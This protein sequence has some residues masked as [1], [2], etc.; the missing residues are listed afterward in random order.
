MS[1]FDVESADVW[2]Q[3]DR[4]IKRN[5][6]V[7]HLR[8]HR[9]HLYAAWRWRALGHP[10]PDEM[11]VL[12][13]QAAALRLSFPSVLARIR[14][15]YDGPIVVL[16]GPEV[17]ALYPKPEL[18]PS[19][20]LDL[21]V[22]DAEAAHRALVARGFREWEADAPQSAEHHHLPLLGWPGLPGGVEVHRAPNWPTWLTPPPTSEL[23]A[24]ATTES[25]L[26]RGMCTV[27][28]AQHTLLLLAHLWRDDPVGRL[29]QIIDLVL[30]ARTTEADD[31][32][33]LARR[34][35]LER[36][37]RRTQ[38]SAREIL[39]D[40]H[41]ASA[42]A[43]L[44]IRQHRTLRPR[45]VLESKLAEASAP[46]F[47][48]PPTRALAPAGRRLLSFLLPAR[49]ETWLTKAKSMLEGLGPVSE[50]TN[51]ELK[52]RRRHTQGLDRNRS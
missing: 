44:L 13:R 7:A 36:L 17:A 47:G 33:R 28:P 23:L 10:V 12:E 46:F 37:W 32:D 2:A 34:W 3:L 52:R 26:G 21:L 29:G 30:M 6:E 4:L 18:R 9:V 39:L 16:K 11:R 20:D 48:L 15:A 43:R 22:P 27:P 38:A 5:G 1:A 25:V 42:G 41:G 35:G 8:W 14:E 51:R 45:S 24:D 49:D 40:G 50:A 19:A 31:I